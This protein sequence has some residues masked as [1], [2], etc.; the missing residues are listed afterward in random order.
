MKDEVCSV[1]E[2]PCFSHKSVLRDKMVESLVGGSA[3]SNV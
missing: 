1:V 2:G 3:S